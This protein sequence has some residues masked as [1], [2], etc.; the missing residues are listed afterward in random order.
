M[1]YYYSDDQPHHRSRL[2][3]AFHSLFHPNENYQA[4]ERAL[5]AEQEARYAS[6][7]AYYYH[8]RAAGAESRRNW[9]ERDLYIA[10]RA[11]RINGRRYNEELYRHQRTRDRTVQYGRREMRR[12]YRAG[13]HDGSGDMYDTA[14]RQS[15]VGHA[16]GHRDGY[17]TRIA[18][19]RA[20]SGYSK[21]YPSTTY[22]VTLVYL[23][24]KQDM[25]ATTVMD[26]ATQ[27]DT[28]LDALKH[29]LPPLILVSGP[30]I[31]V[32]MPNTKTET[33]THCQQGCTIPSG[34]GEPRQL[35]AVLGPV[36]EALVRV[37]ARDDDWL[38]AGMRYL[39]RAQFLITCR[40]QELH[41][42]WMLPIKN[43]TGLWRRSTE[44]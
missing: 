9:A 37:V 8:E 34:M 7:S 31:L 3:A 41:T 12:G 18:Q 44:H 29:L 10:D 6:R 30:P 28:D 26:T 5:R 14:R 19:E 21:L 25:E 1:S 2:G 23:R 43:D 38:A 20:G 15:R 17:A 35:R 4:Q 36:P 22:L 33:S 27:A 13:Y 42:T 32:L 24:W 16:Y 40:W 39:T 11:A